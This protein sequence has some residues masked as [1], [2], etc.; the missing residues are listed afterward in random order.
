M[1]IGY[2][3]DI[4]KRLSQYNTDNPNYELLSICVGDYAK[5]SEWHKKYKL[6]KGEW[7]L[8]DDKIVKKFVQEAYLDDIFFEEDL[9][10][11]AVDDIGKNITQFLISKG[12]PEEVKSLVELCKN[13]KLSPSISIKDC[14]LEWTP[15]I[16]TSLNLYIHDLLCKLPYPP[17]KLSEK[18]QIKSNKGLEWIKQYLKPI[19]YTYQELEDIFIPLFKEHGLKWDRKNS[20]KLYFPSYTSKRK[21]KNGKREMYYRFNN[22]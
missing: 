2:T 20:I 19:E 9:N 5:E 3:N 1:K 11:L 7:G 10:I 14:S 21:Q 4:R 18:P 22:F 6:I 12:T 16:N 15:T 13:K 17:K 8:W